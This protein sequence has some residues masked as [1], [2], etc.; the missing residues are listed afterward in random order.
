ME[1]KL[2]L[3]TLVVL[4]LISS[5]SLN[6]AAFTKEHADFSIVYDDFEIPLKTFSIFVMPREGIEI[7]IAEKDRGQK[8]IIELSGKKFENTKSFK[9]QAPAKS[10]HYPVKIKKK[11]SRGSGSEI[12]LNVFVLHPAEKKNG[13]YLD[14]FK[15]GYYPKITADKQK[16]YSKPVGFLKIEESLLNLNLTPHFTMEQFVTRQSTKFPQ[17]IVLQE[18]LLLKLEYFLEEVNKAGYKADTFGIVSVY[19]SPYFNKKLG[20]NTN[21]SRHLFGDA[22]DIYIDNTG[23]QW[24]DDL[25]EDGKSNIYDSNILFELAVKFDQN[26]KFSQLQGGLSSYNGNGVRGPFLHIDSRGFHVTW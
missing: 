18:S 1:K 24:M 13:Q 11:G 25:N 14:G 22:A 20:N 10:G 6:A 2:A 7:Y 19:R 3:A 15:I 26:E 12:N 16:Y 23:N 4:I 17:Y 5:F 21:F 9:W 8:Y